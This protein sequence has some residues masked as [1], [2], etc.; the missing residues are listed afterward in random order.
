MIGYNDQYNILAG[1]FF[2]FKNKKAKKTLKVSHGNKKRELIRT[3]FPYRKYELYSNKE[4]ILT[5]LFILFEYNPSSFDKAIVLLKDIKRTEVLNFKN[6]IIYY[7]KY[8]K[9]D[10][11]YIMINISNGISFYEITDLFREKKINWFTWY[12][13]LLI[14]EISKDEILK[15]KINGVLYLKIEKLLMF[16]S[17]SDENIE[18]IKEVMKETIII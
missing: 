18:L 9:A 17:F 16:I 7:K 10:I 15:S 5:C 13:Y 6:S 4:Y 14:K 1:V 3:R 2:T 8:L 11:E 12:F